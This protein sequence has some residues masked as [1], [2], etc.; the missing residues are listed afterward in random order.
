ML[1]SDFDDLS[2]RRGFSLDVEQK[3]VCLA[4]NQADAPLF[5]INALAGVGTTALLNSIL[6]AA[7][8][9]YNKRAD[10]GGCCGAEC[11]GSGRDRKR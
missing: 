1:D 11:P 9:S 5:F 8:S 4:L 6:Y 10:W 7:T 2:R 3:N